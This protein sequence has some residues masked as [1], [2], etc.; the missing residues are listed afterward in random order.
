M[1][2]EE[3]QGQLEALILALRL[4]VPQPHL[5]RRRRPAPWS[6]PDLENFP[7]RNPNPA[8]RDSGPPGQY[9]WHGN[10]FKN[11][12]REKHWQ[13]PLVWGQPKKFYEQNIASWRGLP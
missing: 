2:C 1:A 13:A 5:Y 11:Q 9:D 6:P 8:G 12:S 10:F 7:A 4:V 3:L